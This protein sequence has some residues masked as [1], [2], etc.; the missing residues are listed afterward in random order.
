MPA[1][2]GVSS[3][4]LVPIL[5]VGKLGRH[6][7]AQW[8]NPWVPKSSGLASLDACGFLDLRQSAMRRAEVKFECF[9]IAKRYWT[10]GANLTYPKGRVDRSGPLGGMKGLH[11][12]DPVLE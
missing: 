11:V 4:I 8:T 1:K 12:T 6:T 2:M 7:F 5:Y 3:W 10:V 9:S